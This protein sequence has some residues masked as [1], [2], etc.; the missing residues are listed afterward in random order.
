M[1]QTP[2]GQTIRLWIDRQTRSAIGAS[3]NNG[4]KDLIATGKST[5]I[6]MIESLMHLLR[7]NGI[8]SKYYFL[9]NGR[10]WARSN[11]FHIKVMIDDPADC[12]RIADNESVKSHHVDISN[13]PAESAREEW[14]AEAKNRDDGY[15]PGHDSIYAEAGPVDTLGSW[16]V[17]FAV[18]APRYIVKRTSKDCRILVCRFWKHLN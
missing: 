3:V 14:L 8:E 18:N 17:Y 12:L 4:K 9:F 5:A 10:S 11:D 13:V 15:R 1:E 2:T 7:D 6:K 16:T